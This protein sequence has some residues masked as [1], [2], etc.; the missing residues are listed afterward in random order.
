MVEKNGNETKYVDQPSSQSFLSPIVS[1]V[2]NYNKW[3]MESGGESGAN[4]RGIIPIGPELLSKMDNSQT[5]TSNNNQF[6][7]KDGLRYF[8]IVQNLPPNEML[9]KFA[10]S[11]PPNVQEAAK[12]TVLN[13]IGSMPN[14]A[15]DALMITTSSKLSKLL[16]QMQVTGYM[17][18]NAEYRMSLTRLLKGLPRLPPSSVVSQGNV[19]LNPL[20]EGTVVSAVGGSQLVDLRTAGGQTVRV[21]LAEL[22]SALGQEVLA[23]RKELALLKGQREAELKTNLLT[24][25]QALPEKE[26]NRLTQDMSEEVVQ[27]IQLL[28]DTLMHSLG[29]DVTGPEVVIQ[30]SVGQLAQLCMWQMVV[31]YK[32]REVEASEKGVSLD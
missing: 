4:S 18:K 13:I 16:Y 15:L 2:E 1:R 29:V 9:L 31:G 30:Q 19:S 24:Y 11:A 10:K 28:V 8:E 27:A 17:F 12:S 23:L 21:D 25:I 6:R 7:N 32:L 5:V 22:T 20:A 3:R 14:Y 26:L